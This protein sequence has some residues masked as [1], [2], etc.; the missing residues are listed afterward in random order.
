MTAEHKACPAIAALIDA[1]DLILSDMGADRTSVCLYAKAKARIAFDPFID[2]EC[3]EF[4]MPL[5][6]AIRIVEETDNG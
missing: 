1:M 6:E 5:I 4:V 2:A 3:I